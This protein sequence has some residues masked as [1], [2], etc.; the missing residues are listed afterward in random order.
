[1]ELTAFEPV[2]AAAVAAWATTPEETR[3][4][5]SRDEVAAA[6]VAGWAAEPDVVAYV[7][8][9]DGEPVGY[10][11][12]WL[13]DDEAEVELARLIV[14]PGHRGRGAG[15]SLVRML[16]ARARDH[17]PA[18]FLRVHPDNIPALRCYTGAGLRTVPAEQA[19]EWNR[20]QPVP[21]VWLAA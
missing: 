11:E 10:G 8:V 14:A 16:A 19:R 21:Y 5:C 2:H 15:R 4:W 7:A 13:D 6:T 20:S 18:V 12:L 3:H 1:M 9:V 17:H